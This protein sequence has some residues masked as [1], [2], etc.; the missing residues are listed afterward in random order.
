MTEE[1]MDGGI[2]SAQP[3]VADFDCLAG[4]RVVDLSQYE[5][6][7]SCT[8]TL[9]WLGA[10]VVKIEKPETGE[11]ARYGYARESGKDSWYFCQFNANKKSVTLDLKSPR[12]IELL[13]EMLKQ[14][15]VFIE[16]LAP[17]AIERLGVG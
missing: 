9:A 15:D 5:A 4:V 8:E 10:E 14:A 13:K 16:N 1:A 3:Q 17:G 2:V 12:G 6:G 11:P 7:P